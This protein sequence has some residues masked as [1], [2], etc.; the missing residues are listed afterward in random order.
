MRKRIIETTLIILIS[1]VVY[2][3]E[4]QA[5]QFLA[6]YHT[7]I[8]EGQIWRLL[9]ATFC[10]TN[11]NHLLMNLAGLIITLVLFLDTFKTARLWPMIIFNSLFISLCLFFFESDVI[12]YVGLS[13]VLHGLFS[14]GAAADINNKDRWGYLLGIG[15]LVKLVSEQVYGAQQSTIDLIGA[16]V[17]VNAHAYGALAGIVFYITHKSFSKQQV[18]T[19]SK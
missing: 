9:S 18:T 17:M 13:G 7:G 3:F 8:A 4:P 16:Q 12:W 10:H 5:S 15:L 14:Y 1:V 2:L 6:Y 11:L 19:K